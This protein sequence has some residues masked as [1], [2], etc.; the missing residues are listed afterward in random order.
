VLGGHPSVGASPGTQLMD[1]L[2]PM[3]DHPMRDGH[4][5][6]LDFDDTHDRIGVYWIFSSTSHIN[7]KL[8]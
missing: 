5:C 2:M 7:P 8:G 4:S 3:D 1:N 6:L